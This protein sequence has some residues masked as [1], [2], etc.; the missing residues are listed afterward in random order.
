MG[1]GPMAPA[2]KLILIIRICHM[3][4]IK[5]YLVNPPLCQSACIPMSLPHLFHM[6]SEGSIFGMSSSTWCDG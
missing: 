6:E 4:L 5:G 3:V 1:W 2:F